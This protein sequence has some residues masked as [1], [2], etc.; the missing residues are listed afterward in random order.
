[1][2]CFD[3][4]AVSSMLMSVERLDQRKEDILPHAGRGSC[5][6]QGGGATGIL[7]LFGVTTLPEEFFLEN[8]K[9]PQVIC[10]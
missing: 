9:R 3:G 4:K 10:K 2:V 7:Y 1:M 8:A 5:I 6:L